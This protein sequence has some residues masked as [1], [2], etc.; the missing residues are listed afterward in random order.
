M[1]LEKLYKALLLGFLSIVALAGVAHVTLF[2]RIQSSIQYNELLTEMSNQLIRLSAIQAEYMVNCKQ[3]AR[4]QWLTLHQTIERE[5]EWLIDKLPVEFNNTQSLMESHATRARLFEMLCQSG[6]KSGAVADIDQLVAVQLISETQLSSFQ[7]TQLGRGSEQL[8]AQRYSQLFVLYTLFWLAM[9]AVVVAGFVVFKQRVT[10]PIARMVAKLPHL[11]QG[12]FDLRMDVH[13]QDEIGVLANAFNN[14]ASSLSGVM[15]SRDRFVHEA[16]ERRATERKHLFLLERYRLI[17]DGADAGIWDWDVVHKTVEFSSRWRAMRGYADEEITGTQDEWSDGIHPDDRPRVFA[18]LNAHF[19]GETPVFEE[20]YRVRCRDGAWLWVRDRG[21]LLRNDEGRVVRMAGTEEDITE[22]RLDRMRQ[23]VFFELSNLLVETHDMDELYELIVESLFR[24]ADF[25]IIALELYDPQKDEMV[26]T[27]VRGMP[28]DCVGMRVPS[29]QTLSGE[30]ARL[31]EPLVEHQA[32]VRKEYRFQALRAL[33]VVTFVCV[34]MKS[35]DGDVLGTLSVADTLPRR[36]LGRV[37][38]MLIDIVE[39]V[40]ATIQYRQLDLQLRRHAEK[41]TLV[42][43]NMSEGL[44]YQNADGSLQDCNPAVLQLYGLTREQFL[45]RTANDEQWRVIDES[46]APVLAENFPPNLAFRLA[47]PVHSRALGIF[48]PRKNDFVWVHVNAIPIFS[49]DKS[50]PC[51]VFVTMHDLSEQMQREKQAQKMRASLAQAQKMKSVGLLTGGI[52]HDFNNILG[53]IMGHLEL[54]GAEQE[55]NEAATQRIKRISQSAERAAKLVRQLLGFSR[56]KPTQ[57]EVCSVNQL[58]MEMDELIQRAVT[59]AIEVRWAQAQGLWMTDIDSGDFQDAILNLVNNAR[60]A[61]PTG[62]V[63]KIETMN[64]MIDESFCRNNPGSVSG[65]Y[66]KLVVSD[67]GDGIDAQHMPQIFEPFFTSKPVGRG[68]GL[69]LSM[70]YGF[71]KRSG[72]YV[73][74]ESEPGRGTSMELYLPRALHST[75][76]QPTAPIKQSDVLHSGEGSILVVDDEEGLRTMARDMLDLLGYR[77]VL[78]SS[79]EQALEVLASDAS[80]NLLFSDVVMPGGMDGF[81]LVERTRRLYP[82]LKA[83]LS[84]GYSE[85][86]LEQRSRPTGVPVAVLPKPYRHQELAQA[87]ERVLRGNSDQPSSPAF[88]FTWRD[89]FLIGIQGMD[90][91]HRNILTLHDALREA[92]QAQDSSA[93]LARVEQ[94]GDAI[95]A[96]FAHEEELMRRAGY[97]GLENHREVHQLLLRRVDAM[98]RMARGA[99]LDHPVVGGFLRNW[100]IDHTQGM[101]RAYVPHVQSVIESETSGP[102]N[103][104][105]AV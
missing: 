95:K 24:H 85:K 27:A 79:G 105:G 37:Q 96:H 93:V 83:L 100:W 80:I 55:G 91:E 36:S 28:T 5:I 90:D 35:H 10:R 65:G 9:G 86:A 58:L 41:L 2:G 47:Q 77:V 30:V 25:P 21:K 73:K 92:L 87:V 48:N 53:V 38:E 17:M 34:P 42:Y 6:E 44:F 62:G 57:S 18:A 98:Q 19:D 4:L 76:Q 50:T 46:G 52:A 104:G 84:S 101:D 32:D 72:G 68:T 11:A 16:A 8:S 31:G 81:E 54:L 74:V 71:I 15:V 78:A 69:G 70:V 89:E 40:T 33:Q 56:Q 99:Q 23:A 61:M 49:D 59:P 75:R 12:E 45:G 102:G 103:P 43:D 39:R 51:Q 1:S 63:L 94:L 20:E 26:F 3:R 13:R 67:T 88:D 82:G 29:D 60:D 7:V 64:A 97:T 14:M 22:Q 66:V